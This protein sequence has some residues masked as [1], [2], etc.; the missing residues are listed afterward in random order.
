MKIYIHRLGCPKNDV[1]AD[2]IVERL[3]R[4]GHTLTTEPEEAE[5]ILV[6]SCCFILPAREE[7]ID[8]ILKLSR[9]KETGRLKRLYL[10]GCMAQ[11]YGDEML[12]GMPEID[13]AF[14]LG[15]LEAISRAVKSAARMDRTVKTES[16]NL[17]YLAGQ[18]AVT[19][20]YPYAYLKIS[21]GCNRRC[22][23][24]VIPRIRGGFRSRTIDDLLAEARHLSVH[25][26][27]ELVLVS[28]E[29]TLY[30]VDLKPPSDIITLLSHLDRIEQLAWIRPMYLHPAQVTDELI[31]YM[32][33]P[34]KT[35]EYF[36]LPLQHINSEMLAAMARS[37]TREQIELLIDKI[38]A[39]SSDTV[40]RSTFI[41]GFPGETEKQFEEL[42]RFV[43][44]A[45][46]D[47]VAGFVYSP[48]EGSP[49]AK[50][51]GQISEV[52]KNRRLDELMNLQQEIA[53][54]K[55]S[56]LIGSTHEVIIDAVTE[57]GPAEARTRGDCPEVDQQLF[58]TGHPLT[59]GQICLVRIESTE[60]YDL[61]GTLIDN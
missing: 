3:I 20:N 41:V 19:D 38:R 25:G 14:G 49:A 29:A 27:K 51:P 54:S 39:A 13:G 4:D 1:D 18:R 6:N 61:Y 33:S 50:M 34:N 9:L 44:E 53:F 8:E 31:E 10:A 23:Y 2:Y 7:T 52:E 43:E 11:H 17:S 42:L 26:K 32:V 47:R 58:I 24:C 30:G 21:D 46:L 12:S 5:T 59:V 28:Q 55:N 40:I 45:E 57:D 36:D 16:R 35:L 15:E 22:S 60:G 37:T 56:A 48:E